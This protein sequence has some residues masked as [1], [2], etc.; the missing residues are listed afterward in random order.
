MISN[1]Y[2]MNN[3]PKPLTKAY[4]ASHRPKESKEELKKVCH[5]FESIFINYMLQSMRKTVPKTGFFGQSLGTDIAESMYFEVL[6]QE[7]S[8][9]RGIGLA[10]MLYDQLSRY[11]S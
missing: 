1:I 7:L 11:L 2:S 4:E 3:Q 5:D 8:K 10:D 6:A 9:E